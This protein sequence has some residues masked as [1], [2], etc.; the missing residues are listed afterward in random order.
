M[1]YLLDV[2]VLIAWGWADHSDFL[3]VSRWLLKVHNEKSTQ[4]LTTPITQL[5]FIRISVQR[6]SRDLPIV[7]ACKILSEMIHFFGKQHEFIP[8]TIESL[9]FPA[10][11]K[12][13]NRTT[14][15]HLLKLAESHKAR[16]ATLDQ[17]IPGAFVIP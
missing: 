3:K 6:S 14:D 16:L 7:E 5:G 13:A 1:K 9:S 17:K 15:A 4:F 2:N 10:W 12:S 8:D 11:C